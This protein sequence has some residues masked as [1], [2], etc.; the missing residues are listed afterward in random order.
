M[1]QPALI[2]IDVQ[3][4]IDEADHWGGNRN[5]PQ[6]EEN[7]VYLLRAWRE[8]NLPILFVQHCSVSNVS[9]FRPGYTGNEF[10]DVVKP[11]VADKVFKKSVTNAFVGTGL[12]QELTD[13]NISEVVITGFVTNNS[14]E[15]TA[16]M[17][18]DLGFKTT[19]VSDATAAFDKQGIDGTIYPSTVVHTLS[20]SHLK[21]EYASIA[22]T[23]EV[24]QYISAN[25]SI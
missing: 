1:N 25:Q 5:N 10:K 3:K 20:L 8:R 22:T 14:V 23:A 4:G 9:P 12:Q 19:V 15:A 2:V 21:D 24:L 7:I 17:A 6:A 16:R 13:H 11:F 18:G